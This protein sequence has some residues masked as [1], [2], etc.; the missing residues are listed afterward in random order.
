LDQNFGSWDQEKFG[1]WTKEKFG[2]WTKEKFGISTKIF[3]GLGQK[4][5]G[6]LTKQDSLLTQL[7]EKK[8]S[9]PFLNSC[10][11]NTLQRGLEGI[12]KSQHITVPSVPVDM[13]TLLQLVRVSMLPCCAHAEKDQQ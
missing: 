3:F 2:I 6:F 7:P 13:G 11:G 12:K 5:L 1:I 9:G 10:M 4:N 8:N